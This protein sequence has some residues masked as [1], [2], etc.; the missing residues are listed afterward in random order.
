V[1]T[2]VC[3]PTFVSVSAVLMPQWFQF[4]AWCGINKIEI[5]TVANRTHNDARNWL[6]TDGGGFTNPRKLIDKCY[7]IVF[8][9]SDQV[10]ALEDIKQLIEHPGDF[11]TGWYVKG[12]TPMVARW[13]EDKF[14]RTGHMDFL[15]QDELSKAKE[16]IEVDYCGFGFTKIKTSMLSKMSYPYFTNKQTTIGKYSENISEDASFCLD[17]PAKPTVIPTLRVGH[18]K[19]KVI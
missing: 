13:D 3:I 6:I 9:D 15:T 8:I 10:F 7:Q 12:D 1:K 14:I 2:V 11:V 5:I 16:D 18:L 17:S 19:E 4:A